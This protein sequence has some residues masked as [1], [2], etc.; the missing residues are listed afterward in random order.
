MST[1][2]KLVLIV[3]QGFGAGRIPVAPGTFGSVLGLLVAVGLLLLPPGVFVICCV[4]MIFPSVW[5]CGRAEEILQAKDPASVVLDE[6]VAMPWCFFLTKLT[7]YC[8]GDSDRLGTHGEKAIAAILLG[9]FALF[10]LFDIWKPWPVRQAQHLP[11]GWGVVMDDV[12]AAVYVNL[13][14]V[15]GWLAFARILR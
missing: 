4:A 1:A 9:G 8:W 10:R 15:L 2:D 6:I 13:A 5:L 3:A 14:F 12:L 11:R 7:V